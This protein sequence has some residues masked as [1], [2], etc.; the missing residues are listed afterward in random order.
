MAMSTSPEPVGSVVDD[1]TDEVNTGTLSDVKTS[2]PRLQEILNQIEAGTLDPASLGF[3]EKRDLDIVLIQHVLSENTVPKEEHK[4]LTKKLATLKRTQNPWFN[5]ETPVDYAGGALL[6]TMLC[7]VFSLNWRKLMGLIVGGNKE[8]SWFS[9]GLLFINV[10][11]WGS[12][13]G[14]TIVIS[15][16]LQAG[17]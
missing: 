12:I 9:K 11:I 16:L 1:L 5:M 7:V 13:F 8:D 4:V 2:D 15:I 6:F 3:K 14:V 10:V 17:G